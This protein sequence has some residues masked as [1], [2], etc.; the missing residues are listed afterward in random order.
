MRAKSETMRPPRNPG[1]DVVRGVSTLLVV[2]HHTAL[3]IPLTKTGL[4][5]ILPHRLLATLNWSG[6]DAVTMFFT[7]SGFLIANHAIA[8]WGSLGTIDA[9]AFARRF[10][11]IAPCLLALI[12]ILS[13]LDLLHVPNATITRPDQSLPRAILAAVFMHLN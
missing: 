3:R 9:R 6:G 5:A 10:G 13:L 12:G 4:A 2:I 7:V 1:I 8:R 11:R